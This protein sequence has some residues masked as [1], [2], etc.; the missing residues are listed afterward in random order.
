MFT[1]TKLI[2][3]IKKSPIILNLFI[4]FVFNLIFLIPC[5]AL[6]S[7]PTQ[8]INITSDSF[9]ANFK[10]HI[11]HYN[12][13]VIATQGSRKLSGDLATVYGNKKNEITKITVTGRPAK[14]SYQ[15]KPNGERSHAK[16]GLIIYEPE[17]HIFTII[18]NAYVEQENN[19]YKGHKL[20]YNTYDETIISP[21]QDYK[22][23]TM[24]LQPDLFKSKPKSED[25]KN[26]D[27]K[28]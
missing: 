25:T 28:K 4:A 8:P 13:D 24:T 3:T 26:T 23:G 14:F 7:D 10:T 1:P 2:S 16:G 15:P 22:R 27:K 9:N 12:G 21:A 6:Q 18:G 5:F 20:I 17:K 19:V 11:A